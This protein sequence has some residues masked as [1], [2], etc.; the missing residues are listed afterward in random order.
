MLF[1]SKTS[2]YLFEYCG[3][4]SRG[5]LKPVWTFKHAVLQFRFLKLCEVSVAVV[6][7]SFIT[8]CPLSKMGQCCFYQL[9]QVGFKSMSGIDMFLLVNFRTNV[10]EIAFYREHGKPVTPS[11]LGY[12]ILCIH[13]L[14]GSPFSDV[15]YTKKKNNKKYP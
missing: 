6:A 1:S 8:E 13:L 14:C 5:V 12:P 9:S 7:G 15:R 3:H 11:L 4:F 2:S 10:H